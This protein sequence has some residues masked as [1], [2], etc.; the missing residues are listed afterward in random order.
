LQHSTLKSTM[1]QGNSR[2][3]GWHQVTRP[4]GLLT[5]GGREGRRRWSWRVISNR[6][7]WASCS[8]THSWPWQNA[9][10]H[11]KLTTWRFICGG[12]TVSQNPC[13]PVPWRPPPT[14]TASE[15]WSQGGKAHDCA[16][17]DLSWDTALLRKTLGFPGGSIS[18]ESACNAGDSGLISGLGR[19][20]EE[21]NGNPFQ[22]S[23][24][25]NPMDRGA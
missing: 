4:E 16:S 5:G 22:Y 19:S 13:Q 15:N 7:R 8:F 10:S 9:H 2:H 18:K 23:C 21:G 24:L 6:R 17:K 20:P 12:P 1:V 11:Q 25:G 3:T 14:S